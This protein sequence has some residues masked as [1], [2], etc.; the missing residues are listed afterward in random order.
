MPF[1]VWISGLLGS[2]TDIPGKILNWKKTKLEIDKLKRES[3][4]VTRAT[5]EDIK[6]YDPKTRRLVRKAQND[7]RSD[8]MSLLWHRRRHRVI[9]PIIGLIVIALA[10]LAL[11]LLA[12]RYF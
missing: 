7:H 8:E 2:I 12:V 10:L 3:S 4:L 6:R 11:T 1:P 9:V 5:L